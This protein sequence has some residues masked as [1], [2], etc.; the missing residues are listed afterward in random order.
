VKKSREILYMINMALF[1]LTTVATYVGIL[2]IMAYAVI[3]LSTL[4]TDFYLKLVP[5]ALD[6]VIVYDVIIDGEFIAFGIFAF[7][8][9]MMT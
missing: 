8:G 1:A 7:L 5:S 9:M 6:P 2:P 3:I 4:Y